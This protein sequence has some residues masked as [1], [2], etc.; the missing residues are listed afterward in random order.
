M[1]KEQ[2]MSKNFI[3]P[4]CQSPLIAAEKTWQ[5]T[6]DKPHTFDVAKQGYV[7]L[8]PVQ[9]KKSKNPGDTQDSIA[10]RQRFLSANFYQPL[11]Q[12]I[13]A[14]C[15]PPVKQKPKKQ[16]MNWLDI[17]C[18][19]GYYTEGFISL[20]PT[21]LIALDISKP[22]V[23]A[24]AKR[25]KSWKQAN[26]T[27]QAQVFSMVASASQVPLVDNSMDI[28]TSIFSPILPQ[29]FNR[30]LNNSGVVIIAKPAEN[31][32]YQMRQ[33]LFDDVVPHDSDKFIEEMS[34][35]FTLTNEQ[36]V[37]YEI[38]VN[39]EQLTDLVNMT[40]YTFR[41]KASNRQALLEKCEWEGQMT[42]KVDFVIYQFSKR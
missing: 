28:I 4:I 13:M 32:L 27:S 6:N 29:E 33:E 2:N 5:C 7:N 41:A 8:L 36:N 21:Q 26:Q 23:M 19:E 25:L 14:I 16:S 30:L 35:F 10:S 18:G 12:T 3:C 24:T 9:N 38:A 15:Q 31:H 39:V 1:K 20:E 37:S 34:P 17:G 22:A 42:L 11:R 40:P